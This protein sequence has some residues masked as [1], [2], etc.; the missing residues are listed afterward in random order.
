MWRPC[1]YCL[2]G[3]FVTCI[4]GCSE[5]ASMRRRGRTT[6]QKVHPLPSTHIHSVGCV[7]LLQKHFDQSI[8]I[9]QCMGNQRIAFA[10]AAHESIDCMT[11]NLNPKMGSLCDFPN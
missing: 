3:V 8:A 7:A 6:L 2:E 9:D 11:G 1:L 4:E 5:V 10:I